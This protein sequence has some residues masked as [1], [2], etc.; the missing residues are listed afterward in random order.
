MGLNLVH[1]F[2]HLSW[3]IIPDAAR[4]VH[5]TIMDAPDIVPWPDEPMEEFLS[6]LEPG[7]AIHPADVLFTKITD[8]QV[9]A[10]QARFGG[11]Q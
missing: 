7:R 1:L 4:K 3:P 5:L 6:Q 11:A 2:G 9:A 10:W 8:E